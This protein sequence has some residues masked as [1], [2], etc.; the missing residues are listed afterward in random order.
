[1]VYIALLFL[2]IGIELIYFKIADKYNIIDKPNSR[3]SHTT[4][5]LRGGGII[6][7]I[8][9]SIAF[10]LGYVSWPVTLAVLVVAVVSF[11]DD[12]KPLSQLPRFAS[13]VIAV[14]LVFYD[15]NLFSQAL[16]VLPIVFVLMIGW[17]NAFNFMDGINGITVLY[18]LIAIVSFAFLPINEASLPLLITMGLSCFVFGLF[19]VRKKAKTFAGDVGSISMALFLGYLMIKT[20]IGT[21]Q[22]A[23][24]L[25]FSVYGID[26]IITIINRLIKREN[27][28]QPHRSHLYQ[29]L[30]NEKG[31]SHVLV[32][33]IYAVLQLGINA[34]VIYT[35]GKGVMSLYFAGGILLLLTLVYLMV[36]GVIVRQL[37]LRNS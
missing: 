3:S 21:G 27:I 20:I 24:I 17:V 2:L 12:I 28:F 26:A 18:A 13:H 10:F 6:F 35:D 11:I 32:S 22:F 19:N 4:I 15:L 5:T 14:G 7:P 16:W 36:R 8:A 30:A 31:Y 1:M 23:Y 9:I 37:M 25:F 34:I 33:V 29:Y